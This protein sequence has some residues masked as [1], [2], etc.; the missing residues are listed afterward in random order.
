MEQ[1]N[2]H[3]A[4]GTLRVLRFKTSDCTALGQFAADIKLN[5]RKRHPYI[6][7]CVNQQQAGAQLRA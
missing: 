5:D 2:A 1:Q 4:P 6:L 7:L 3:T